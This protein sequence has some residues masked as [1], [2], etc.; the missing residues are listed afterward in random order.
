MA[1]E[2][3]DLNLFNYVWQDQIQKYAFESV[4]AVLGRNILTVGSS[5]G[6]FPF[7]KAVK[8]M[9]SVSCVGG[10]QSLQ[11]LTYNRLTEVV[12]GERPQGHTLLLDQGC[13]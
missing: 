2:F 6:M 8:S 4:V 12:S 3:Q 10:L 9:L 5:F 13:S 11:T 1:V 7:P